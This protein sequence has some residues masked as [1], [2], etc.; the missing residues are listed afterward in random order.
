MCQCLVGLCFVDL[1]QNIDPLDNK[2]DKNV[3]YY[4]YKWYKELYNLYS[5]T[6]A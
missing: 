1:Q 5:A 3:L 6:G 2:V 4:S